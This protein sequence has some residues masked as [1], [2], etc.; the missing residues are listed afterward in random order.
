MSFFGTEIADDETREDGGNHRSYAWVGYALLVILLLPLIAVAY[1]YQQLM[2]FV[3][4]QRWHISALGAVLTAIVV[5]SIAHVSGVFS[6]FS[7]AFTPIDE[8]PD[9]YT[10]AIPAILVVEV[11]GGVIAGAVVCMIR[12]GRLRA[13]P[14]DVLLPGSSTYQFT[15]ARTPLQFL[16]RKRKVDA[17]TQENYR[18]DDRAVIGLQEDDK[19]DDIVSVYDSEARTHL[20]ITGTTG[21]GKSATMK[22]IMGADMRAGKPVLVLDFK[23]SKSLASYMAYRAKEEGRPFYHFTSGKKTEYD[24]E[25]SLG[26]CYYDPLVNGGTSKADMLLG[27]REYDTASDVYKSAMRQLLQVLFRMI[28]EMDRTKCPNIEFNQGTLALV[29]S[30]MSGNFSEAVSACEGTAIY[31]DA[32]AVEN[33]MKARGA[34]LRNASEELQGQM[35]TLFASDYGRWL[36]LQPGRR[37]INLYE[38]TKPGQSSVILFS[39]SGDS[40]KDFA[41]YLGSL[42]FA[43][44]NALSS[45]RRNRGDKNIVKA[46]ADEFQSVPPTAVTGILEK[47]RES[48]LSLTMSCQSLEQIVSSSENNGES[49]LVGILDTISNFIVHAGATEDSATRLSKIIGKQEMAN[50]R[51]G[52]VNRGF[53]FSLN[54]RNRRNSGVQTSVKTDWKV[55]PQY[56]MKVSAPKASGGGKVGAVYLTKLCHDPKYADHTGALARKLQVV[57][58]EISLV[59][60]YETPQK[61]PGA[62]PFGDFVPLDDGGEINTPRIIEADNN[63]VEYP[64]EPPTDNIV[65]CGYDGDS[66]KAKVHR[67]HVAPERWLGYATLDD[68]RTL[69]VMAQSNGMLWS[70]FVYPVVAVSSNANPEVLLNKF[71]QRGGEDF[72]V[73]LPATVSNMGIGFTP[74]MSSRGY[75]P[76]TPYSAPGARTRVYLSWFT[77]AQMNALFSTEPGYTCKRVSCADYPLSVG[78]VAI[79]DDYYVYDYDDG[80]L[81]IDDKPVDLCSQAALYRQLDATRLFQG[82]FARSPEY[83]S[84][85][86]ADDEAARREFAQI[87]KQEEMLSDSGIAGVAY[88]PDAVAKGKHAIM[89]DLRE[90]N[91]AATEAEDDGDW[92]F[93][94]E[95]SIMPD[96]EPENDEIS[97]IDMFDS[98]FKPQTIKDTA[99][100]KYDDDLPDLT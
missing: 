63:P 5:L 60:M 32:V 53:L 55:P 8:F 23:A 64:W 62:T 76:A 91:L 35:R 14:Q 82:M 4:R 11:V 20:L 3:L 42:I 25:N 57:V 9:K 59:D 40:E 38:L 88:Y 34:A 73:V 74:F 37:A 2:F 45:M 49:Y 80:F 89:D 65:V 28:D 7:E 29:A 6:D 50:Y 92:G 95:A 87:L 81:L 15:Y 16:L 43:D 12:A 85:R 84:S 18:Y 86:F 75:I 54:W 77:Q 1:L 70:D 51:R 36:R 39:I 97:F 24:I 71:A 41:K 31:D 52:N 66:G 26:N 98:D 21:S 17:L 47:A 68:G 56:F 33:Q 72:F 94:D 27:M 93:S 46:Y 67:L 61:L 30:I 90:Q 58:P 22:A 44:M 10:G 83:V 96:D 69:N 99:K 19:C 48:S 78:D 13:N 79:T 100:P